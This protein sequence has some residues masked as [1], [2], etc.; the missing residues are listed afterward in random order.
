MHKAER[1][2]VDNVVVRFFSEKSEAESVANILNAKTFQVGEENRYLISSDI[3]V[4]QPE[5]FDCQGMIFSTKSQSRSLEA[6]L[7]IQEMVKD[8]KEV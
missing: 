4:E 3:T 7:W 1:V 5:I 8:M 2:S 6:R